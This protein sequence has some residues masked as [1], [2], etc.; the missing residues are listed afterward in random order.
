MDSRRHSAASCNDVVERRPS[1]YDRFHRIAPLAFNPTRF[2]CYDTLWLSVCSGGAP[3]RPRN[4]SGKFN[5]VRGACLRFLIATALV[6]TEA[7]AAVTLLAV[8]SAPS[9]AQFFWGDRSSS[10]NRRSH[11]LFDWFEQQQ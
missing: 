2:P 9:D 8:V 11:G 5:M 10:Q 1:A 6:A 3:Y 4:M 7:V